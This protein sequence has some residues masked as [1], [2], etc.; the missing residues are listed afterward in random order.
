VKHGYTHTGADVVLADGT[1]GA[2][3]AGDLAL[4]GGP[5]DLPPADVHRTDGGSDAATDLPGDGPGPDAAVDAT[6]D[7]TP[8]GD[9][10][11]AV[12]CTFDTSVCVHVE[13]APD[14]PASLLRSLD[15]YVPHAVAH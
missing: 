6:L 9:G 8:P 13:E 1:P 3:L 12:W 10:G 4:E 5:S 15:L 2:D 7:A 11:L 14:Q